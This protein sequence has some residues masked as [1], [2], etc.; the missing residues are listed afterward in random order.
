MIT[1]TA[2]FWKENTCRPR[3]FATCHVWKWRDSVYWNPFDSLCILMVTFFKSNPILFKEP[4]Y[5][6][7]NKYCD[8]LDYFINWLFLRPCYRFDINRI[9]LQDNMLNII[10]GSHYF[11]IWGRSDFSFKQITGRSGRQFWSQY[12]LL[13]Q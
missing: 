3:N 7:N 8:H 12:L 6:F 10:W 2:N 1:S 11:Q 13:N 4:F 9:L 5:W